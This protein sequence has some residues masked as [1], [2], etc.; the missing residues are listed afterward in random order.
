M[1]IQGQVMYY[2]SYTSDGNS[3]IL[4]FVGD[5]TNFMLLNESQF[6]S[7]ANPGVIKRAWFHR[8]MADDS[9][10]GVQN[11]NGAAT[12]QSIQAATGG[13]T[14]FT[15]DDLQTFATTVITA[16]TAATPVSIASVAHGLRTGDLVRLSNITAMQQISGYECTATRTDANNFTVPITGAGF[17]AAGTGGTARRIAQDRPFAPR[18]RFLDTI[19]AAGAAVITTT[20]NHG[21]AVG[22]VVSFIVPA[23]YGMVEINNLKGTVTAVGSVVQFTVDI[24]SAAFTAF[25]FPTSAVAALGVTQAHVIPVGD[26][27]NVLSGATDN[28]GFRGLEL[29]TTVVGA[30]TDVVRWFAWKGELVT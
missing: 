8:D 29:G 18:R 12:D 16:S 25:A 26:A 1:S 9:Y 11:T 3:R 4:E 2:G 6:N 27:G 13:F 22:E 21:F 17:A 19:S 20:Q 23:A 5:V 14:R 7:V 15:Y 30:N 10:M 28:I 24:N